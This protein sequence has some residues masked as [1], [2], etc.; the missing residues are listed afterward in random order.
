MTDD[1]M[2]F[3]I[4]RIID[5][6]CFFWSLALWQGNEVFG[7]EFTTSTMSSEKE[8]FSFPPSRPIAYDGIHTKKGLS[9]S[10]STLRSV[11]PIH[12]SIHRVTQHGLNHEKHEDITKLFRDYY[13]TLFNQ[14]RGIRGFQDIPFIS[15]LS[16]SDNQWLCREVTE[17]RD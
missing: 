12:G 13:I 16:A 6:P 17:R 10:F 7:E 3:S 14:N 8:S 5:S 1:P 9:P 15:Q 4:L 11:N 2:V